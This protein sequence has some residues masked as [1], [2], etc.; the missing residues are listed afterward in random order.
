VGAT[1]QEITHL[2][3][4]G[5][6]GPNASAWL[7]ERGI[8][9]PERANSWCLTSEDDQNICVRLGA[10]EF[11]LE[12]TDGNTLRRFTAQLA[13]FIP[14]VY[15]VLREDRAFVLGGEDA[16]EVLAQ[17]CNVNF[18]ALRSESQ[19]A[20]MTLMIGVAVTVVLQGNAAQRRYR[21][22]CDPSYGDYLW[23]SLQ[24]V[25]HPY[26]ADNTKAPG[27]IR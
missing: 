23:S 26:L 19:E 22:W 7:Q 3:R 4:I 21:I 24:E 6:K 8:A 14:G 27:G 11:L 18:A 9:M 17:M 5:L 2:A 25:A 1:L 20:V 10:T 12:Q 15:L 13:T 16:D